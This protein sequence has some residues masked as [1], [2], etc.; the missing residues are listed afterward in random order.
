MNLEL[1]KLIDL[2]LADGNLTEKE[3]EILTRKAKELGIDLD[4]LQMVLEGKFHL[5]QMKIK[6]N[7]K[8]NKFDKCPSCGAPIQSFST[9]CSHCNY[10][11]RNTQAEKTISD[12]FLA[13]ENIQN[14]KHIYGDKLNK[15]FNNNELPINS[16]QV[17]TITNFPVPNSKEAICEFLAQ[18]FAKATTGNKWSFFNENGLQQNLR[19]AWRTKCTEIIIK[20]RF[21]MKNDRKT[22][23][24]IE[25]YARQLGIK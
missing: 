3:K 15:L 22:L 8:E 5:A 10:E 1:E 19:K 16:M 4:E 14:S 25:Y 24:E 21:S 13:L 6:Q 18:A 9:N 11:F 2:A 12:L 7:D 17:S 20:A 23:E